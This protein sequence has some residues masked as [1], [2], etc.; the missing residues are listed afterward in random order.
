MNA[1]EDIKGFLKGLN[2]FV[3]YITLLIVLVSV[4]AAGGEIRSM[5]EALDDRPTFKQV[6][7]GFLENDKD[8]LRIDGNTKALLELIKDPSKLKSLKVREK[9]TE[10]KKQS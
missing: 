3:T 1:N 8:I 10:E 5:K 9:G 2:I 7:E 6:D 4:F